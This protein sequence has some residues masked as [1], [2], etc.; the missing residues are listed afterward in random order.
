MSNNYKNFLWTKN[1]QGTYFGRSHLMF[2]GLLF[3]MFFCAAKAVG[4]SS[5]TPSYNWLNAVSFG[6]V[7]QSETSG[8]T[9]AID[10]DSNGNVYRLTFGDGV[11]KYDSEGTLIGK[12]IKANQLKDPLDIALDS[13]DNIYVIDYED[14]GDFRDNGKIRI[15]NPLGFE[16]S[17]IWTSYFRPL[18]LTLDN[19][20]NIYVVI[21]NDGSGAES[22][23][24]SELRVYNKN[25]TLVKKT[26]GP[27]GHPLKEPYRIGVD[28]KK[29]IYISHTANGGEVLV[30]NSSYQ[31]LTTLT[32][33]GSPGSVV[34]DD[35]DFIHVIDYANRIDFSQ[36]LDY[37]D[38]SP[39]GAFILFN[40]INNGINNKEFSIRI[41]DE[42]R[43]LKKTFKDHLELPIDLGFYSCGD[44][45]YVN[46]SNTNSLSL[47][48]ELEIYNRSP[49]FD[50]E[51]PVIVNCVPDQNVELVNKIFI[52]LDYSS[53]AVFSAIDNCDK[54]LTLTQDPPKNTSISETTTVTITAK[55][56]AGN[57]SEACIFKIIIAEDSNTAPVA[58]TDDN[59]STNQDVVL[60]IAAPGVLGNDSDADNDAL[61]AIIQT[62]PSNGYVNLNTDGSFSYVPNSGFYGEDSL[63]YVATDGNVDS[64]EVIVT[65]KVIAV[66][67]PSEETYEHIFIYPNPTPGPFTFDTPS[68]WSIEKVEVYDARGRY[69]LTETYS[70]NQIEYSMDLRSLQ[71]AVYI[72][73]LYTSRGIRIIRVI[74]N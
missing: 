17:Q 20:D 43:I 31:Y 2:C 7:S 1:A 62:Q 50:I 24:S 25:G 23:V 9:I 30:L 68:G 45:M 4:Q 51:K 11:L 21:Y 63:S 3:F 32:G 49:S 69:V 34:I 14:Q 65:I 67:P 35:E 28:S 71:Q 61:T 59:Y 64:N 41:Y 57:V 70:E 42:N 48:F 18:G 44:R 40:S 52:L 10:T 22:T 55:D 58:I 73:K 66:I 54:D 5:V 29:N 12:I 37:E 16:L 13:Q 56:D 8:L 38:I 19:D 46:N 60:T 15:F 36:L 74:I 6:T 72:L 33:M 27:S 47:E 39:F 26:E 53:L